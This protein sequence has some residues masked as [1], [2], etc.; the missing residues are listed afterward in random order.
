MRAELR[1][2]KAI[3]YVSAKCLRAV[4]DLGTVDRTLQERIQQHVLAPLAKAEAEDQLCH[5]DSGLCPGG[6]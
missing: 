5:G 1:L 4:R 3:K 2:S 6:D